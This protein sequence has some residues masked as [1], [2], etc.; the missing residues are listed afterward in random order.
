[1]RQRNQGLR[2]LGS[3]TPQQEDIPPSGGTNSDQENSLRQSSG[4]WVAVHRQP[5]TTI[6]QIPRHVSDPH[7]TE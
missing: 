4:P 5:H 7:E 3:K 2:V 1:M 6:V